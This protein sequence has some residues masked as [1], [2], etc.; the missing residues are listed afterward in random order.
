[1][2]KTRETK[3]CYPAQFF[4]TVEQSNTIILPNKSTGFGSNIGVIHIPRVGMI[5]TR[6][7][8]KHLIGGPGAVIL[9]LEFVLDFAI[10]KLAKNDIGEI[11]SHVVI[12]R[13]RQLGVSG[14]IAGIIA[15]RGTL[16][17]RNLLLLRIIVSLILGVAVG[18]L[19]RVVGL[20]VLRLG[21]IIGIAVLG[22]IGCCGIAAG[23]IA[24]G[25]LTALLGVIAVAGFHLPGCNLGVLRIRGAFGRICRCC[26]GKNSAGRNRKP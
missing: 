8:S 25:I 5:V 19:I 18:G 4:N 20:G 7:H 13:H 10:N 12:P 15:L 11:L 21:R 14:D 24:V 23:R 26:W 9:A 16:C 17:S 3:F 22:G 6:H 1:M 2:T